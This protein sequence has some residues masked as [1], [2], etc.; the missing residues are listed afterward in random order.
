MGSPGIP[1]NSLLLK[2]GYLGHPG[3]SWCWGYHEASGETCG[4]AL[5]CPSHLQVWWGEVI[6]IWTPIQLTFEQHGFELHGSTYMQMFFNKC[7]VGPLVSLGFASADST[8]HG[9]KTVFLI[10]G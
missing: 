4:I 3:S 7:T 6:V 9:S 5:K 8:N 2:V 1:S 10:H